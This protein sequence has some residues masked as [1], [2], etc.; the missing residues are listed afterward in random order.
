M[1]II[2]S[3]INNEEY[4]INQLPDQEINIPIK[5]LTGVSGIHVISIDNV[6]DFSNGNCLILEDLIT[7]MVYDLSIDSSITAYIYDTTTTARFLLHIG[8]P[9]TINT[10]DASC[11]LTADAKIVYTKN[12]STP[13]DITWKDSAGNIISSNTNIYTDSINNITAGNYTI[14]TTDVLCGNIIDNI[15]ITAPNQITSY[16]TTTNDTSYLSNGGNITFNNQSTNATDYLWDFNDGTNSNLQSPTH[17]YTQA[18]NYL[19]N[20]TASINGNCSENYN[21]LITVIGNMTS[22]NENTTNKTANAFI[23]GDVLTINL[24]NNQYDNIIIR[25]VLGQIIY[26]ENNPKESVQFNV[27]EFSSNLFLITLNNK[28]KIEVIKLPYVK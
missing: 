10:T 4:S 20:L 19:V 18:G 12:S 24:A 13:F 23:N 8:A 26:T 28:D 6:S 15:I 16:Y 1:P 9:V 3:I 7:G 27:S 5:I 25:N 11:N 17:T 14:E 22:I 21:H 2:S